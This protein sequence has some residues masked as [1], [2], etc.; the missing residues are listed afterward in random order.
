MALTLGPIVGAVSENAA[1]IWLRLD[2]PGGAVVRARAGAVVHEATVTCDLSSLLTGNATLRGLAPATSY[3]VEVEDHDGIHSSVAR[4]KTLQASPSQFAFVFASCHR[5]AALRGASDT[6]ALW[7]A[8]GDRLPTPSF[9]DL[10]LHIGDQIYADPIYD[11]AVDEIQGNFQELA[12][13]ERDGFKSLRAEWTSAYADLYEQHWNPKEV[14][15][16]LASIPNFMIWDDHDIAD[17]WGSRATSGWDLGRALFSAASQA[18]SLYQNRHNPVPGMFPLA[19]NSTV[20]PAFGYGFLV[21]DIGFVVPDQRTFRQTYNPTSDHQTG[22]HAILGD[23]QATEIAAWLASDKARSLKVLFFVATVPLFHSSPKTIGLGTAIGELDALDNWIAEPNQPDLAFV[24]DQLFAWQRASGGQAIVLGGDVHMA[25]VATITLG[26][27]ALVQCVSSPIT[28]NA[29]G[30]ILESLLVAESGHGF[31]V[32]GLAARFDVLKHEASRNF[33]R[34]IVD[35]SGSPPGI[36]FEVYTGLTQPVW[37]A[38][39]LRQPPW[40]EIT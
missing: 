32:G 16:V 2:R 8:L 14:A 13:A 1:N 40:V 34:V 18:Y 24:L 3:E 26:D 11:K 38:K 35:L 25:D 33:G 36:T 19:W 22:N 21:G 15:S 27:E 6:F 17:G 7:R 9:A 37:T 39:I 30:G 12:R 29:S 20:A 4:F 31:Q 28:N 10:M 5:P 23:G